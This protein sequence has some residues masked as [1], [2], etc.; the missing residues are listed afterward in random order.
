MKNKNTNVNA[1]EHEKKYVEFLKNRIQSK[2]FRANVSS[3]EL[4]ETQYKYKKAK[5]KLKFLTEKN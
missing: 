5:L 4:E 2:N 3:A 1:V